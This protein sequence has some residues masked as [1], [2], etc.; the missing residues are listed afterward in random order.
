VTAAARIEIDGADRF[1]DTLREVPKKMADGGGLEK[2][3]RA[4]AQNAAARAPVLTGDLARSV[5]AVRVTPTAV[6][7]VASVGVYAAVQEYG[8]S[9]TPAHPY[10]RPAMDSTGTVAVGYLKD[11]ADAALRTVKGA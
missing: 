2:A 11:D 1:A 8:S 7:V 5:H 4:A 10:M 6:L 9:T 3:G